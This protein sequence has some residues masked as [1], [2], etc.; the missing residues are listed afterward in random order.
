MKFGIALSRL[1]FFFKVNVELFCIEN[2]IDCQGSYLLDFVGPPLSLARVGHWLERALLDL[3]LLHLLLEVVE[4]GLFVF[5]K[6]SV[7]CYEVC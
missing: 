2:V 1:L 3:I 5:N 7:P 6:V 4:L